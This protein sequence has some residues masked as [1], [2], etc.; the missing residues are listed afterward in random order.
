MAIVAFCSTTILVV[1]TQCEGVFTQQR[2]RTEMFFSFVG[3]V[4]FDV[5]K[6]V[7]KSSTVVVSSYFKPLILKI[8]KIQ[9]VK[10]RI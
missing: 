2:F 4:S 10:S 1:F 9:E 6:I 8:K 3:L 7:C 5:M